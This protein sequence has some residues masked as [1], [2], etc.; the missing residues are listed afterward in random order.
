MPPKWLFVETERHLRVGN[1]LFVIGIWRDGICPP[2]SWPENDV[3][4]RSGWQ[5]DTKAL[6]LN[7]FH[8]PF[9][10]MPREPD[11]FVGEIADRAFT[12]WFYE[13]WLSRSHPANEKPEEGNRFPPC[14]TYE[15][16]GQNVPSFFRDPIPQLADLLLVVR[17]DNYIEPKGR[18]LGVLV[19]VLIG[20][21]AV[22]E[23]RARRRRRS[24]SQFVK[25]VG[26]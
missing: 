8:S 24:W 25:V 5:G 19:S 23:R 1:E 22:Q 14:V 13:T 20:K 6:Q 9:L 15:V 18:R 26:F 2:A 16:N 12:D 7:I 17:N 3:W 21:E 10:R 4:D 11:T